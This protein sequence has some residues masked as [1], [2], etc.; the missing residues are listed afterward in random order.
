MI[1]NM[2]TIC[3]LRDSGSAQCSKLVYYGLWEGTGVVTHTPSGTRNCPGGR[4]GLT[5]AE[6]YL[7]ARMDFVECILKW[8]RRMKSSF[9][10][11]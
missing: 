8:E 5:F 4:E 10:S 2:N 1:V 3:L 7:E 11:S 6:T 9:T